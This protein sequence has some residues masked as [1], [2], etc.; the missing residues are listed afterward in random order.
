MPPPGVF[1]LTG[2]LRLVEGSDN[3]F[4]LTFGSGDWDGYAARA[5]LR[6]GY[7]TDGGVL[8]GSFV[9]TIVPG[10]RTIHFHLPYTVVIPAGVS[11]GV[12]DCE[13]YNGAAV[14]RVVQGS[15]EVNR[16]ATT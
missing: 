8:I 2:D 15:W 5:E 1:N 7:R 12:W 4:T 16:E 10:A 9:A 6:D 11:C 14:T 13:I 3:R